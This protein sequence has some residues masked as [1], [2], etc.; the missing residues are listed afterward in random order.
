M[1]LTSIA[2]RL[3][4]STP[5]ELTF[6]EQP[7]ATGRKMTTIF[8]H[9]AA[10]GGT[11]ADYTVR[12][13][14]NAGDPAAARA[15]IDALAGAGSQAGAMAHAFVSANAVVPGRSNFPA[16]RVV[17]LPHAETAFGPD[18]RALLAV[19]TLRTDMFVSCY[20]NDDV[21]NRTRLLDLAV[22]LSGVDRDLM[23]Q[24]GSFATFGEIRSFDTIAAGPLLDHM[25]A[26]VGYKQDTAG[27]PSEPVEIIAA[28]LAGVIMGSAFPYPPLN[29]AIVGGAKPP[30]NLAD[31]IELSPTG[32]SELALAAGMTPLYVDAAGNVRIVR[33]RTARL[34]TDGSTPATAY[35][36]WQEIV[37]LFDYREAV[38]LR[39]QQPDM[40]PKKASIQQ[41]GLIKDE[42]LRI[43]ADFELSGAFQRVKELA[44][45]F[46]VEPSKTSR[47]RFDFKVPANVVP[48]NHVVAGNIQATT[49]FDSFTL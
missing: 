22:L 12:T 47:G 37:P 27:T 3:T 16:F 40:K 43:A 10:T 15:E 6:G 32:L 46:V 9:R 41:A 23:G 24:F 45:L 44:K 25:H 36:D 1:A 42:I 34:T 13:V 49:L 29:G 20:G 7:V 17:I 14:Q 4:P 2:D 35:F 39:L 5:I 48:G 19:R 8:G 28:R 30:V 26:I 33:S 18:D 31:R 21:A 11:A 38:Y